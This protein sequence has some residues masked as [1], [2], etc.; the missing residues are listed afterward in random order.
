[1]VNE[2]VFQDEVIRATE[3]N[4]GSGEVLNKAAITPVTIVRNDETFALMRRDVAAHWRKEASYAV[5]L[6][7]VIWNA[8]GHSGNMVPECQWISAFDEEDRHLMA[9]ELMAGYR[10]AVRD[11][12]WEDFE[13]IMH[14]WSESGWAILNPEVQASFDVPSESISLHTD[15]PVTA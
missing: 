14:E 8:L 15:V 7:E 6:T 4:R 10:K 2:E 5:H 3:M 9:S 1:M 11:G 13:A 12:S